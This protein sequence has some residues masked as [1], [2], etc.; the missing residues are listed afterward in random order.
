MH[1]NPSNL[2][3]VPAVGV[4]APILAAHCFFFWVAFSFHAS[5]RA[6]TKPLTLQMSPQWRSAPQ[7]SRPLLWRS[8]QRPPTRCRASSQSGALMPT[9]STGGWTPL[10]RRGLEA[11]NRRGQERTGEDRRGQERRGEE[12]RGQER[13]GQDRTGQ[14]RAPKMKC[15]V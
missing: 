10:S 4:C 14:N 8:H 7:S 15:D 2:V 13:R 9:G 6:L 1:A 11:K 5:P 12:R 3:R